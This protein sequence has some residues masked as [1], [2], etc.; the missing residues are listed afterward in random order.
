[1]ICKFIAALTLFAA[2]KNARR[3]RFYMRRCV[4]HA[5]VRILQATAQT[6]WRS[7]AGCGREVDP[8][9]TESANYE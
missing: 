7:A 9:G 5:S 1:L 2:V 3:I 8:C 4:A 6:S